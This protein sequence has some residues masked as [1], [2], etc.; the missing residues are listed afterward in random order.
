MDL[1]IL[2]FASGS[3]SESLPNHRRNHAYCVE[4]NL[5]FTLYDKN[6]S[7]EEELMMLDGIEMYGL[8]N[9]R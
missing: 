1:C 8:G 9:W 7:A 4:D 3:E 5:A 2:C 6:W